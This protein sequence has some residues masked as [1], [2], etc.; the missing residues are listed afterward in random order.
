M[1]LV[2]SRNIEVRKLKQGE[3]LPEE[4]RKEQKK[5]GDSRGF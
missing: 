4:E 2:M 5:R 3:R 1:F